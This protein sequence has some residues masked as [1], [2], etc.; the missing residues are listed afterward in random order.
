MAFFMQWS[1][2]PYALDFAEQNG[3]VLSETLEVKKKVKKE[4]ELNRI[5]L[6][7]LILQHWT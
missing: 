6:N 3:F 7:F 1:P 4:S 5:T 2:D